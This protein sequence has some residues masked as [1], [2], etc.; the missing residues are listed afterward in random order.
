MIAT[1]IAISGGIVAASPT[2]IA[3]KP[4][5][6]E[7][8]DKITP[9]QGWIGIVLTIWSVF[10]FLELLKHIEHIG[11]SWVIR[12]GIVTVEFTVGFLLSY[13]LISKSL[14][15]KNET[16]KQEGQAL[17]SKLSEYQ[18]PAGII[19]IILGVLSIAL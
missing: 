12:L 2:I 8:I 7:L 14:L 6:K 19:L 11:L 13:G 10:D 15:E 5:A 9:Y 18:I 1:V 16:A 3:K 17:R 4:N